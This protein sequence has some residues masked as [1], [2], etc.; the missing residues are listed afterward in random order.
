MS[1]CVFL[2]KLNIWYHG[3]HLL[4]WVGRSCFHT[5]EEEFSTGVIYALPLLGVG[6]SKGLETRVTLFED[7]LVVTASD[8]G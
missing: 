3:E 5:G 4:W 6:W 2:T 7:I 1:S 8:G